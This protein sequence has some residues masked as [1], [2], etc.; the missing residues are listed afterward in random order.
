MARRNNDSNASDPLLFPVATHLMFD[1]PGSRERHRPQPR[2]RQAGYFHEVN[3]DTTQ[4][5]VQ[6]DLKPI[7]AYPL[8]RCPL[9]C[10]RQSR[11]DWHPAR[12][13]NK[14]EKSDNCNKYK[15]LICRFVVSDNIFRLSRPRLS[16]PSKKET[17]SSIHTRP[18]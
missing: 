3:P 1:S 15:P 7:T 4:C 13:H 18:N 2:L 11:L 6:T 14:P 16:T 12:C 5:P 10:H 8:P 17:R 9:R